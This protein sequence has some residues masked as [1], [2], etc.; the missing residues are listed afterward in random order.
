MLPD[1]LLAALHHLLAFALFGLLV[2]QWTMVCAP[3]AP[4]A[5]RRLAHG[6]LL[7]GLTALALLMT[8]A[9]RVIWGARGSGW[10]LPNGW[11]WAKLA[12]FLLVG[13]ASLPPTIAYR[14][15][16]KRET[17]VPVR[18]DEIHAV[19]RWIALQLG[20]F[21]PIPVLAAWMARFG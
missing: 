6:D 2:R 13:L 4:A 20:L 5:V 8:G 1:A 9:A 12:C 10:F 14:S 7:Y 19:R 18:P 21:L 17:E 15:W 11:F 3:L 16:L